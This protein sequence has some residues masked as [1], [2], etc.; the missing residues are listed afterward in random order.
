MF[1]RRIPA[2][3]VIQLS[4]VYRN[5]IKAAVRAISAVVTGQQVFG[6]MTMTHPEKGKPCPGKGE[7]LV[8]GANTCVAA[9][10]YVASFDRA[11]GRRTK[12]VGGW[13]LGFQEG[14]GA[15]VTPYLWHPSSTNH[16]AR[17][18]SDELVAQVNWPPVIGRWN[19]RDRRQDGQDSKRGRQ[20]QTSYPIIPWIKTD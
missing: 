9:R 18:R 10:R 5:E 6:E 13:S 7:Q 1:L 3:L 12:D 19:I 11:S 14:A 17:W 15:T 20:S 8:L 2:D 4:L 16:S